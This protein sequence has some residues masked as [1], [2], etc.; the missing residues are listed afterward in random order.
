MTDETAH[1]ADE[2][3]DYEKFGEKNVTTMFR[4]MSQSTLHH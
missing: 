2:S 1:R 3:E 4:E